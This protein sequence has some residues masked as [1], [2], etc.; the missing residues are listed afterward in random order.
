MRLPVASVLTMTDFLLTYV[1]SNFPLCLQGTREGITCRHRGSKPLTPD[2]LP[3]RL[4]VLQQAARLPLLRFKHV[5]PQLP[6]DLIF[7]LNSQTDR[8]YAVLVAGHMT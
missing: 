5:T 8:L 1:S 3:F 4:A 2:G 6:V 7:H